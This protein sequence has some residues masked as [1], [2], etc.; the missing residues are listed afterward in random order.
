VAA[1]S[2][3][4]AAGIAVR[5]QP[6]PA[7]PALIARLDA[8]LEHEMRDADIPGLAVAVVAH[9]EVVHARG[10]GTA[11]GAGR[12]VTADTPF[13]LASLTKAFTAV[14]IMQ[15]V[16]EGR[17]DL[18]APARRYLPSFSPGTPQQAGMVDAITVR[19]LLQHVSGL[20]R[21]IDDPTSTAEGDGVDAIAR[22]VAGLAGVPLI[23]APGERYEYGNVNY[24]VLGQV[25]EAVTG[26]PFDE[27]V[28][29]RIYEPLGMTH[30]H[31]LA[32]EAFADGA[33]EGFYRWFG[34][35]TAP[36]RTA[37]PRA[38]GPAGVSF[39]SAADMGRWAL[40]QL[41]HGPPG[42]TVLSPASVAALHA[43]GP[44]YDDRHSYGLGWVIRPLW[45]TL[46]EPPPDGPI[47]TPVPDLVEHGGAWTT[48]HDYIGL[49]PERDWG[50][51]LLA[52]VN[53]ATMRTRYF[54]TD[55]GLL[56][57][58]AGGDPPVPAPFEPPEI[59]YGKQLVV[60]LLALQLLALGATAWVTRRGGTPAR[61]SRV[62][63]A[64]GAAGA[65]IVDAVVVWLVLVAAPAWFDAPVE[66]I[67][68]D[69]PDA[70]PLMVG[71]VLLAVI[72]G[73]IRTILL[74][75]AARRTPAPAASPAP[76]TA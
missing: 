74:L 42:A 36:Y 44:Q 18:D 52:N 48:A 60:L 64:T 61:R 47:T 73:P 59:R 70:G 13:Q 17:V 71:M 11:D 9:G 43:R 54:W 19:R 1:A 51:V 65:L 72:W 57:L 8:F 37:Y 75:R 5:T 23:A 41:G 15:L 68:R 67:V 55:L 33:S 50:V 66:R 26:R 25:V 69:A 56:N 32:E 29:Q 38:T 40:F 4:P 39:S 45:E 30:S 3:P 24:E 7:D 6:D 22:R 20:P 21:R 16:E 62:W 76:A 10:F 31:V 12:P 34:L 63:I 27:V 2:V 28:E 49:V 14:A 46:D 53:D 58:L 35:R